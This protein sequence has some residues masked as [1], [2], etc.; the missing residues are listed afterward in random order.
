M[1]NV[2]RFWQLTKSIAQKRSSLDR[3]LT[4]LDYVMIFSENNDAQ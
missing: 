3:G 4:H 2:I 1:C